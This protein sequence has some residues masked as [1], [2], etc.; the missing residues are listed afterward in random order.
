[1]YIIFGVKNGEDIIFLR[2]SLGLPSLYKAIESR[3]RK[4]MD[5]MLDNDVFT[6]VIEGFI[7]N[8]VLYCFLSFIFLNLLYCILSLYCVCTVFIV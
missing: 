5:K 1:V 2:N 3:R 8:M 4:F 6:V 7:S